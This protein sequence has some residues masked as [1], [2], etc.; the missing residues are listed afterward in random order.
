MFD[1]PPARTLARNG[2]PTIPGYAA[3][4]YAPKAV[5]SR[6][7]TSSPCAAPAGPPVGPVPVSVI[8]VTAFIPPSGP[9]GHPPDCGARGE[10]LEAA[11]DVGEAEALTDERLDRA[12]CGELEELIVTVPDRLGLLGRVQA[13]VQA[14][15]GVVLDQGVVERRGRHAAAGEA[16]DQDAAL[17][18]NA[19]GGAVVGVAADWVVDDVGAAP[20]GDVVNHRDEILRAPVHDHIG[21]ERPGGP[22]LLLAADHTDNVRPG[23]LAELHRGTSDPPA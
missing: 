10:P 19:L 7:G 9:E 21:T 23:R 4:K 6:P 8:S 18:R 2:P 1:L 11:D 20:A 5:R 17:E 12:V 3:V 13:P 16:D 15:D 14:H 22:G